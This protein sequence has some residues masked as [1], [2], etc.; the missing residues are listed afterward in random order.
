MNIS[1]SLKTAAIMGH[2]MIVQFSL[3]LVSVS[4]SPCE[5]YLLVFHP[6]HLKFQETKVDGLWVHELSI[7]SLRAYEIRMDGFRIYGYRV[8]SLEL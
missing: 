5:I 8:E 6:S 2:H 4:Q 1:E 7:Y 3:C